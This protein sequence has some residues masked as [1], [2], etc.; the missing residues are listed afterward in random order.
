MPLI[1]GKALNLYHAKGVDCFIS[2]FQFAYFFY[3][4]KM[5]RTVVHSKSAQC[6]A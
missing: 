2:G 1:N 5:N 3:F 6:L 4:I